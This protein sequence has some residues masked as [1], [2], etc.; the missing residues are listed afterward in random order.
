MNR[1][2]KNFF[3]KIDYFGVTFNFH[4]KTKEKYTS[5][6][7]GIVFLI[8][9][10]MGISFVLINFISLIKRENMSIISYK[11]HKPL[12][13]TINFKNYSLT[14]AF[15][16]K[17]SRLDIGKEYDYFKISVNQVKLT[18]NNGIVKYNKTPINYSYCTKKHFYNKFNDSIDEYGLNQ[19]FCFDDENITIRGLYTDE[20]YQYIELTVSM[21]KTNKEDYDTYYNLLTTNDCTFQLYHIDYGIDI[22]NFNNPVTPYLRQEF[23]KLSPVDFNKMEIYYLTEKFMTDKNYFFNNY[24][25]KYYAGYSMFTV[26]SLFKGNDRLDKKPDAYDQLAKFFLRAD[27][28]INVISRKYMK[29]TEFFANVCSLIS[30]I[31]LFLFLFMG[32]INKFYAKERIMTKT[33]QFK[34]DKNDIFIKKLKQQLPNEHI[35]IDNIK[36]SYTNNISQF[37]QKIQIKNKSNLKKNSLKNQKNNKESTTDEMILSTHNNNAIKKY[38]FHLDNENRIQKKN[39]RQ[40]T[41]VINQ[42]IHFKY[43]FCEL[44]ILVFCKCFS[45]KKLKMKNILFKNGEKLLFLSSDILSYLKNMQILDILT[46]IL[47]EPSQIKMLKF[48]SK[49]VISINKRKSST[50]KI[51]WN[52]DNDNEENEIDIKDFCKGYK[53]IQTTIKKTKIN[54]KLMTIVNEE[55]D[56]LI[57]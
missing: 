10:I 53:E 9:L 4:Y 6:S 1:K 31:Y 33:F 20:I 46:Y 32:R 41:N 55:L 37:I 49:P 2:I 3:K 25:I 35:D 39:L 28:R 16:I 44:L 34:D 54:K 21:T 29:F 52:L 7:G 24:H 36:K 40:S 38:F 57:D 51:T 17:C 43:N 47:L 22:N 23:L 11:I 18:Q 15:G 8:Y 45:W 30:G 56:N 5:Y 19:R 26:F 14:H 50:N 42:K 12:T 27:N 13:E 48:A